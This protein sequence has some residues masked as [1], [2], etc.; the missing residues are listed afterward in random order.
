MSYRFMRV[1][2]LFDLP[3]ITSKDLREYRHFRNNLIRGGFY[4]MQESVYCK[5]ELNHTGVNNTKQY[6]NK[7]K[8]VTGL[9]QILIIT[10][11]QFANIDYLVGQYHNDTL[12][13]DQRL[14]VL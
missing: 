6:L 13:N 1:I 7:Y 3:M 2:V 5:M 9:V 10:E 8:P 11:K 12:D 4:M 14:V